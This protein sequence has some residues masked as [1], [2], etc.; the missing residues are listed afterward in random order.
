MGKL[1][2]K[3]SHKFN[4]TIERF[5]TGDDLILDKYLVEAD[6]YG[7]FAHASMLST[8]GLITKK[9]LS[10]IHRGFAKILKLNREGKFNL[11]FGDEDIHTKIENWLTKNVGDT[12]KKI[13]T[14]RSRNDQV[15][16]AIRIYTKAELLTIWDGLLEL[17][18]L[19]I[20]LSDKYS[21]IPMP[22]YTHMQKAMPSSVGMW[23]GAF[24]ESLMDDMKLLQTA[25]DLNNQSPL[26]SGAGYG[27]SLDLDRK[28]VADFLGFKKVQANSLYCQNSRGKFESI[29]VSAL[30]QIVFDISKLSSDILL[31]TTS[32]FNF[33]EI[34]ESLLTGSSIMPQKRNVD[35]AELLRSKV[36]I[37]QGYLVQVFSTVVNLPSGYNRDFQ[38]IKRPFIESINLT[39]NVINIV[40]ILLRN[41]KP[42]KDVLTK[43]MTPELYATHTAYQLVKNGMPFREA[44]RKIENSLDDLEPVNPSEVLKMSR[45]IGG[46]ANLQNKAMKKDLL[47]YKK[48]FLRES[49]NYEKIISNF[50]KRK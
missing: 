6:V 10:D 44:Y 23:F 41:I 33:F 36:N 28:L 2:N 1:W 15:L 31:F 38:D 4:K 21:D 19:L 45:H 5:E 47:K 12:G 42:K 48:D 37:M 20:S 16:L 9:E 3:T 34:D 8:I 32:E 43:S 18:S 25:F 29:V 39:K 30:V 50:T 22:G 49:K 24:A 46:T 35:V 13:H 27:V 11:E 26:G 14:G 40:G 7:S 17:I